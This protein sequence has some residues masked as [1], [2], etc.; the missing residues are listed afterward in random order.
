MRK[1]SFVAVLLAATAAMGETE[2]TPRQRRV[3][4]LEGMVESAGDDALQKFAETHV[5]PAFRDQ[6]T[7]PGLARRLEGLVEFV[8]PRRR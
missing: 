2:P 8:L 1:A 5:A 4:A 3:R 7:P 6:L